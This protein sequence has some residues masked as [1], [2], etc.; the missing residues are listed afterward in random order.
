MKKINLSEYKLVYE[1]TI[2]PHILFAQLTNA[3]EPL[4][5]SKPLEVPTELQHFSIDL[6]VGL[7]SPEGRLI[8][9]ANKLVH[10]KT[11]TSELNILPLKIIHNYLRT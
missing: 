9:L 5:F 1:I 11:V 2:L 6:R 8:E 4:Y 3:D 7:Y 10:Y